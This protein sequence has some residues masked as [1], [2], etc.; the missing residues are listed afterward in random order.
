WC[1]SVSCRATVLCSW[2]APVL[3]EPRTSLR[4]SGKLW[5]LPL[6]RR[7]PSFDWYPST[8]I[9][10]PGTNDSLVNPRRNRTFGVPASIAQFTTVPSGC[11]TSICNH[12]WGLT[13]SIFV[14]VPLKF[15]G[16]FASNSAANAWCAEAAD[17][18]PDIA[19]P[20]IQATNVS[21]VR[22]DC[23][24]SHIEPRK[25]L[26]PTAAQLSRARIFGA[27]HVT[28]RTTDKRGH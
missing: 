21:F 6:A 11:F 23:L 7:S 14:I 12:V 28:Y 5:S 10:V 24:L 8:T 15:T 9:S 22:I 20:V 19:R 3:G 4:T 2:G 17:V 25:V 27:V 26:L 13:H 16:L 1:Y 18:H